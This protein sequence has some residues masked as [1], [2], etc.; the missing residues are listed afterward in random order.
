[1]SIL[2][3]IHWSNKWYRI[4]CLNHYIVQAESTH[5]NAARKQA[6]YRNAL[7]EHTTMSIAVK[8]QKLIAKRKLLRA[9]YFSQEPGETSNN[10]LT[11]CV[12]KKKHESS[13]KKPRIE[14]ITLTR[15]SK[16]INLQNNLIH[17]WPHGWLKEQAACV[18]SK[19]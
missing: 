12:T 2:K 11:F 1:M 10:R 15:R 16:R 5:S 7:E 3:H 13:E 17:I 8:Q 18:K 6:C 4:I 19:S 9:Y 14:M